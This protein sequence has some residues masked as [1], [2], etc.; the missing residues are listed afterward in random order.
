MMQHFQPIKCSRTDPEPNHDPQVLALPPLRYD[1]GLG[2]GRGQGGGGV[3][4]PGI[5]DPGAGEGRDTCG[6]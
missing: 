1:Q 5:K 3:S 4:F 6:G 2:W